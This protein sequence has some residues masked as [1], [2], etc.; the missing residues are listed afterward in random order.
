MPLAPGLT[1]LDLSHCKLR[2]LYDDADF[3]SATETQQLRVLVLAQVEVDAMGC[4]LLEVL[5]RCVLI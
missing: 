1:W 4:E 2:G 3:V 5:I